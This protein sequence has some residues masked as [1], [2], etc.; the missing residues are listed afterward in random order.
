MEIIDG[1]N[2]PDELMEAHNR[3]ELVFFVGAGASMAPPTN[4]PSYRQ[5]AEEL[6]E[7]AGYEKP[8]KSD[9]EH[10]DSFIGSLSDDGITA[11][12]YVKQRFRG[13]G[14]EF[15]DEHAA[16]M[17]L[18]GSRPPARI[19]T[20]NYDDFLARAAEEKEIEIGRPYYA[21]AFPP[22]H[23]FQGLL[24]LHGSVKSDAK[25]LVLDDRD[26]GRAYLTEGWAARFLVELF[27]KYTVLFIGYSVNDPIMRYLALGMPEQNKKRYAFVGDSELD[28]E[29]K[30]KYKRLHIETI[31]YPVVEGN[32]SSLTKALKQWDK[33]SR[34]S[35]AEN[36]KC[37]CSI[38]R[39][40]IPDNKVDADV[41]RKG[42]LN[43]A[44]LNDF[45]GMAKSVEWLKWVK[46]QGLFP[47]LFNG[48]EAK[49]N[50]EKKACEWLAQF[51]YT[52]DGEK[53]ILDYLACCKQRISKAMYKELAS[54]VWGIDGKK[55]QILETVLRT[56]I[57]GIT[58]G[59]ANRF[60]DAYGQMGM[61]KTA[62]EW[63]LFLQP[64]L[65]LDYKDVSS[66]GIEKPLMQPKIKVK[67]DAGWHGYEDDL[68]EICRQCAASNDILLQFENSLC[69]ASV[70][71]NNY[72]DSDLA[73]GY[74][75]SGIHDLEKNDFS[76]LMDPGIEF[77]IKV[78]KE[79]ARSCDAKNVLI[80]RWQGYGHVIFTRLAL[81]AVVQSDWIP[82]RKIRWM[83]QNDCLNYYL[84]G[85]DTIDY[86]ASIF[87]DFSPEI[88]DEL[89]KYFKESGGKAGIDGC[90][91]FLYYLLGKIDWLE[92]RSLYESIYGTGSLADKNK[93]VS[94]GSGASEIGEKELAL[95]LASDPD[96][97][98]DAILRLPRRYDDFESLNF[99][100]VI[101]RV[102][103]PFCMNNI[104]RI[105]SVCQALSSKIDQDNKKVSI[106]METLVMSIDSLDL[107]ECRASIFEAIQDEK[108]EMLGVG[109][110]S[111]LLCQQIS[112]FGYKYSEDEFRISNVF[113]INI[114]K[115]Y[116]PDFE[117]ADKSLESVKRAWPYKM[118]DYWVK[119]CK[120]V[121]GK[122]VIGKGL[123][124]EMDSALNI[125]LSGSADARLCAKMG[126][127][128]YA[129]YFYGIDKKY[130][131]DNLLGLLNDDETRDLSWRIMLGNPNAN[132]RRFVMKYSV[133]VSL[134]K[135]IPPAEE[136]FKKKLYEF[137]VMVMSDASLKCA[138]FDNLFMKIISKDN[139][140]NDLNLFSDV[141]YKFYSKGFNGR[142]SRNIWDKWISKYYA[143][144]MSGWPCIASSYERK[145]LIDAIAFL[146][147]AIEDAMKLVPEEM[148]TSMSSEDYFVAVDEECVTD[149]NALSAYYIWR[150]EHLP[151][152]VDINRVRLSYLL[153]HLK[154]YMSEEN[155]SE[156]TAKA[157]SLGYVER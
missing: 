3:G 42:L 141:F 147:E 130:A 68:E 99:E 4:F 1:V 108:W 131:N 103:P 50:I 53:V 126:L 123:P 77:V 114:M 40:G 122:S 29:A 70:L 49:N 134:T 138:S 151:K 72:H 117:C 133:I 85:D 96:A 143:K 120:C 148:L 153:W 54:T 80:E 113:A 25:D 38:V 33:I 139:R 16:I 56:S 111:Q 69:E 61:P 136:K 47:W 91:R 144:R 98:I 83:L 121:Y 67:C 95:L 81:Y 107:E 82:D 51:C 2:I 115:K 21:P 23:D 20:T 13:E 19:V 88:H 86:V 31:T 87:D 84:Y 63:R 142:S 32:H 45:I 110:L 94:V 105:R 75:S 11:H 101:E 28:E 156:I 129:G 66:I 154:K 30:E 39:K 76:F 89:L 64:Y 155:I 97:A 93:L 125:L 27:Q 152:T 44:C 22:G 37:F 137:A 90:Q 109:V 9:L 106:L 104:S 135:E 149:P 112:S 59:F 102:I 116:S 52:E 24:H 5:L 8:K 150:I 118:V 43:E 127:L 57:P 10:L 124:E 36:R 157:K 26:F 34:Y 35:V 74:L 12:E 17:S 128:Y 119:R 15:N 140:E 62:L 71:L 18:A 55:R 46:E 92:G 78:L 6:A 14:A 65:V 100:T 145:R 146:G 79:V 48:K 41:I 73:E 58:C 132:L 7:E 60:Y